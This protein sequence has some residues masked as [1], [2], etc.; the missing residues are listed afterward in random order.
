MALRTLKALTSLLIAVFLTST[1]CGGNE[2]TE[3]KNT[4]NEPAETAAPETLDLTL[5]A[6]A[7]FAA[8]IAQSLLG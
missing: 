8:Q 4:E 7:V 5:P 2:T 1:A 6:E 3:P